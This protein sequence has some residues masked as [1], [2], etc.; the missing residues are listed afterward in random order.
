MLLSHSEPPVSCFIDGVQIGSECTLG[1]R[2]IDAPVSA[3]PPAVEFKLEGSGG[4]IITIPLSTMEM[5]EELVDKHGVE[6][7]GRMVWEKDPETLFS[8]RIKQRAGK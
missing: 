3:G 8:A 6:E 7:A 4:V 2:N 5:V 1:K